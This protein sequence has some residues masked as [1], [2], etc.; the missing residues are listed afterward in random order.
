MANSEDICA[1]FQ[2]V[3]LYCLIY[4]HLPSHIGK[5]AWNVQMCLLNIQ[6]CCYR[7]GEGFVTMCSLLSL[8][9]QDS[10]VGPDPTEPA[11]GFSVLSIR[12]DIEPL[13][14]KQGRTKSPREVLYPQISGHW[15]LH[16]G[17]VHNQPSRVLS[18]TLTNNRAKHTHTHTHM[19]KS[20]DSQLVL[21]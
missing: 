12:W 16:Y 21:L 17:R 1:M 19:Q 3:N 8:K 20:S 7:L 9:I 14:S 6:C 18:A 4:L 13:Y 10:S 2:N 5:I 15:R 11:P